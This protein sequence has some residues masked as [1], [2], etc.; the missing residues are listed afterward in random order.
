MGLGLG[1]CR[2]RRA[3]RPKI[4]TAPL[5]LP[6]G[7]YLAVLGGSETCGRGVEAPYPLLL[8]RS[9]GVPCVNL[10]QH[11][12]SVELPLSDAGLVRACR[13]AALRVVAVTGAANLSNRLYAVHPRRKDRFLKPS[14]A[15]RV[16]FPEVDFADICFTRHLLLA[17]HQTAPDRFDIVREELRKAWAARMRNLL[18][19]IGG[20]ALL[21]WVAG[22]GAA[23]ERPLG[24][25]PLFVTAAMVE[26]VAPRAA[27]LVVVPPG[28]PGERAE[29][30]HARIA[31]AL[32]CPVRMLLPPAEEVRASA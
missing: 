9:L 15:L 25:D 27:G 30:A 29:D 13:G 31:A 22:R 8:E 28:P 12:G 6:G 2:P 20:P 21:L 19:R 10:G 3:A 23:Q 11:N 16:L 18:D 26:A 14:P 4:R 1:S 5:G 17:L 7:R 24:P 32:L